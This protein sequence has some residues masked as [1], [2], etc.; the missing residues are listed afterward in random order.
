MKH[1]NFKKITIQN[2]LST[3]QEPIEIEFKEGLNIINGYNRD[4]ADI[5]NAVGKTT[6]VNAFYF[7]VFGN[8]TNELPKQFIPNRKIGRNCKVVL[9]F[10]NITPSRGSETFVI[11]R[12]LAPSRL[13]IWKNGEEKTKSTIPETNKYIKEVLSAN[14]EIFQD[15]ICMRANSTIPFMAKKKVDKK[16]F[17]ESI[18]NLSIFSE[19]HKLLKDDIK[20]IRRNYDIENT[21][22]DSL[23]KNEKQYETAIANLEIEN[24]SKRDKHNQKIAEFGQSIKN[25]K[26][27][28]EQLIASKDETI[29]DN[30]VID[31]YNE[32]LQKC[33]Q[34]IYAIVK[35]EG[36][37]NATISQL[38][39]ESIRLRKIGDFCPTCGKPYDKNEVDYRENRLTEI[40]NEIQ[41]IKTLISDYENKRHQVQDKQVLI[42]NKLDEIKHAQYATKLLNEKIKADDTRIEMYEKQL[43]E[44]KNTNPATSS[45]HFEKLLSECR[46]NI[47][48]KKEIVDKIEQELSKMNVCEFILSDIGVR[49]FIVGKLL[50]LLNGRIKYYMKAFKSTFDFTFDDK[51]EESIKDSNGVI[52]LYANCSGAE[53]K[54]ID[55]AISFAFLDILKYHHQVQYNIQ[56]FDEILDSS[57]DTKSLEYI[58]EF[59]H[60]VSKESNRCI[61]VVTHKS[62]VNLPSVT[63]YITLEKVNGFTRRI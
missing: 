43:K 8:T 34:Y 21:V 14:E 12:M 1:I 57:V 27:H 50:E 38:D 63:E 39:T 22:Y 55:L 13:R 29:V 37:F 31:D 3:G 56:F 30:S 58:M 32:K 60:G 28:R 54:K 6:I 35:K 59:I 26:K 42:Q 52:C 44:L 47:S 9:E 15:C 23:L 24:I 20:E 16:N 25:L 46:E 11:E 19:M 62:D 48:Y 7:V 33:H 2:F 10:E 61:Y 45:V 4:E 41:R 18:F 49:K 17:I 40:S 5:K 36:E 51:F 53:A